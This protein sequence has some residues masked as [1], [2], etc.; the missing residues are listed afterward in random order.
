[1][2]DFLALR[3]A[4]DLGGC[5]RQIGWWTQW[6]ERPCCNKGSQYLC[7]SMLSERTT[8]ITVHGNYPMTRFLG[9]GRIVVEDAVL[10]LREIIRVD[11]GRYDRNAY[12]RSEWV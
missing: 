5:D 9:R 2:L 8:S 10:Q 6:T 1:M 7:G 12:A 4:L 11:V 3:A